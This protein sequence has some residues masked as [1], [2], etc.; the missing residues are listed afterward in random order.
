M[1]Y[2]HFLNAIFYLILLWLLVNKVILPCSCWKQQKCTMNAM[3]FTA[4]SFLKWKMLVTAQLYK[5]LVLVSCHTWVPIFSVFTFLYSDNIFC[6]S[7]STDLT[8]IIPCPHNIPSNTQIHI[9]ASFTGNVFGVWEDTRVPLGKPS[10]HGLG[11][12]QN[13]D[14]NAIRQ[15]WATMLPIF[16]PYSFLLMRYSTVQRF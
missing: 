7:V 9:W 4:L 13:Q 3:T 16:Y 10:K 1:P 15:H 2:R 12:I 11:Q 14:C 5:I 8:H 6:S